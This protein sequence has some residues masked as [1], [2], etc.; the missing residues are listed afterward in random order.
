MPPPKKEPNPKGRIIRKGFQTRTAP[1]TSVKDLLKKEDE[2][3]DAVM[4]ELHSVP[5]AAEV[6]KGS[7][8][9]RRSLH[10]G[11]A[12]SVSQRLTAAAHLRMAE[13]D[14]DPLAQAVA[15]AKGEMLTQDHP[16]LDFMTKWIV[17]HMKALDKNPDQIDWETA[18]ETLLQEA[19]VQLSDSWTP[20]NIRADMTKELASYLY[21]KLKAT[22]HHGT[23]N[24]N[25][26]HLTPLT[27]D[28]MLE[29]KAVF[30]DEY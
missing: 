7:K 28:E 14:F 6:V 16:F 5:A 18:L 2:R 13:L 21:P 12:L 22:E 30:D 19:R 15:I 20:L 23:I 27:R 25:H 9:A 17:T 26:L 3:K 1:K 29:F 24:H 8:S 10:T 4:A 11:G